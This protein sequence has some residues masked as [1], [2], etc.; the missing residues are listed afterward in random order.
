[1]NIFFLSW[2]YEECAKL[3]CDQHVVKILLEIAQMLYT[4]HHTTSPSGWNANAPLTKNGKAHGYRP[5]HPK[6]PM[7]I[8]V[9]STI[10]NYMWT[11]KFGMA[12]ACEHHRRFGTVHSCVPHILWLFTNIPKSFSGN[13]S[14]TARYATEGFPPNLTPPPMCMPLEYHDDN[15]VRAYQNYYK[16]D[17]LRFA[18]WK[19]IPV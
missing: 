7:T 18:R 19:K 2:S 6:H 16:G 9:G 1:M 4:A 12:L 10:N 13:T 15:I 11:V 3:Y 5:A 17:K 14:A 8:W